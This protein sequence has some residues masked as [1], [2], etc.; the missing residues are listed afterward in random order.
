[1]LNNMTDDWF[2]LLTYV[3]VMRL[4][5]IA[6]S[7]LVITQKGSCTLAMSNSESGI[8]VELKL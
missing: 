7:M 2:N 8:F 4:Y 6:R 3:S 1:M 5:N